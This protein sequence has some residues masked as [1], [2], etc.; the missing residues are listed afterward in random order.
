MDRRCRGVNAGNRQ[1]L[2]TTIQT[3]DDGCTLAVDPHRQDPLYYYRTKSDSENGIGFEVLP[4][5]QEAEVERVE[6]S[7]HI[8]HRPREMALGD[9]ERERMYVR[10][11]PALAARYPKW[12]HISLRAQS[13]HR[14][15][16]SGELTLALEGLGFA[17][18]PGGGPHQALWVRADHSPAPSPD[19]G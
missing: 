19:A 6:I 17:L 11:I 7:V 1:D 12:T 3:W 14:V 10:A 9:P 5:F 13:L 15:L 18:E 16:R 2:V 8:A 4:R